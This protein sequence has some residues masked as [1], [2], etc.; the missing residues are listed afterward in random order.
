[1]AEECLLYQPPYLTL[2]GHSAERGISGTMRREYYWS[3]MEYDVYVNVRYCH[4]SVLKSSLRSTSAHYSNL[5]PEARWILSQWT[6]CGHYQTHHRKQ[7]SPGDKKLFFDL[8]KSHTD[9]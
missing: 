5:R 3:H 9:V 2:A 8:S 6:S 4:K 7:I 1:M